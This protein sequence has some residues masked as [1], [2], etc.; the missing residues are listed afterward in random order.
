MSGESIK[1]TQF[2]EIAHKAPKIFNHSLVEIVYR[3]WTSNYDNK[4]KNQYSNN[5]ICEYNKTYS[6]IT[7]NIYRIA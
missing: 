6:L 5:Y 7:I 2:Y 4:N 1:I 3:N